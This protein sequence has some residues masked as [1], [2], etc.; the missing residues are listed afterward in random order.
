[1][2]R[3]AV[4]GAGRRIAWSLAL[5]IL[6]GTVRHR[7][8]DMLDLLIRALSHVLVP[9][10]LVG[11]VGSAVVVSIT[12]VHDIADFLSDGGNENSSPDGLN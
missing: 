12:L 11:M 10:F 7:I 9:M 4:R 3:A 1:M 2:T 5:C 8:D 6:V